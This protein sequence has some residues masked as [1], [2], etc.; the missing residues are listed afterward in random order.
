MT[1]LFTDMKGSPATP[2]PE[3]ITWI[4]VTCIQELVDDHYLI[5]IYDRQRVRSRIA[6]LV[7]YL[8]YLK[9]RFDGDYTSSPGLAHMVKLEVKSRLRPRRDIPLMRA[10]RTIS[11]VKNVVQIDESIQPFLSQNL[12]DSLNWFRTMVESRFARNIRR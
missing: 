5:Y 3:T 4:V 11:T 8:S 12:R 10:V 2:S 7:R 9:Q 1:S 6:E